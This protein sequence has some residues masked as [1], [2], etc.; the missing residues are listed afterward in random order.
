MA[1][2]KENAV[3]VYNVPA[4]VITP[5]QPPEVTGNYAAIEK[6]LTQWKANVS[7][8]KLT[9]DN[10][11]EVMT[12]KKAAVAVRNNLDRVIAAT[13]KALFN[14]P[15]TIFEA[16]VK[17]LYNLVADVEGS[18]NVVLEKLEQQRLED[19]N[20]VLN[21]Y[22]EKLQEQHKLEAEYLE[23]IEYKK[24]FYNK[25][26]PKGYSSMDKY[27]KESLENQFKEFK[28]AQNAYAAN[29]RL[30]ESTCKDEP[31]LNMQHWINQLQYSDVATITENIIAEKD[32]LREFDQQAATTTT[33]TSVSEA[34]EVDAEVVDASEE[35]KTVILGI[36]TTLNFE[37]D[38]PGRMKTMR[39]ELT[40]P[41][42]LV[43]TLNE[44]FKQLKAFGIKWKP[45]KEEV[46]F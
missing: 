1:K 26:T 29:V 3:T 5:D 7:K 22:K 17:T 45:L 42:D 44:M 19:I 36:P 39:L 12:V 15:K 37:S 25:T 23:K 10:M 41:C 16:R 13:K 24:D 30:I 33:T 43:D 11:E 31:R 6:T 35:T 34:V 28:K 21:H 2:T 32:R 40:Y 8:M 27:W 9:E 20:Q 4:L 38:F 46:A 18:A 14:D